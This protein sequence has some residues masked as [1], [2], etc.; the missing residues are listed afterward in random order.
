MASMVSCF[1]NFNNNIA[2]SFMM[3]NIKKNFLPKDF[4]I[5]S[6]LKNKKIKTG[7]FHPL[8]Q[9][10][11]KTLNIFERLNFEVVEG[12]EAETEYYNFD[13]LNFPVSHP[14]R[15]AQDTF[16]IQSSQQSANHEL[17]NKKEKLLLRTHTSPMQIKYMESH[18]PPFN[19]VVPGK[20]FRNERT[21]ASHDMQFYQLEGLMI[22]K[23]ISI[24]N[25]KKVILEFFNALFGN[26]NND[27]KIRMR[28]SY[29]PFVEPGFEVDI[30]CFCDKKNNC[31]ICKG[32]NWIEMMGAGIVHPQV[33]KNAGLVA[34][35]WQGFA[36]GMGLDRIAMIK[37]K[38]PDIRLLYS[39]DLRVIRQF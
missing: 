25:F 22:D 3:K 24:A 17:Q 8:T 26:E 33:L 39:G 4:D 18:E 38:I 31:S 20:C 5:D 35:E 10:M 14:A 11:N 32:E 21:D 6:V 36:F 29:F 27:I 19:I 34:S 28:P 13:A 7:S 1:T 9:L 16:W 12:P 15:D 37:Y 23:D 30:S 2:I